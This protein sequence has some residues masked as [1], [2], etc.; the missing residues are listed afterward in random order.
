MQTH[1]QFVCLLVGRLPG[2]LYFLVLC[3]G[4]HLRKTLVLTSTG[5]LRVQEDI[6][7]DNG[8]HQ[9]NA[10]FLIIIVT[11]IYFVCLLV[12]RLYIDFLYYYSY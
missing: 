12:G 11:V 9:E 6:Q 10:N 3:T 8:G 4:A 7:K 5:E 2:T 1:W